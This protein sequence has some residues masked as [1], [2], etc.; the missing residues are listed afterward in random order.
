MPIGLRHLILR[1][2]LGWLAAASV[3][4]AS[5]VILSSESSAAYTQA[6]QALIGELERRGVPRNELLSVT[7]LEWTSATPVGAKLIVTLGA[8]ASEVVAQS[9]VQIPVLCTLLPLASFERL[10]RAHGRRAS[11]RFTALYLDQP[12]DRQLN[13]IRQAL[14]KAKRLGVLWGPASI[15]QAS[16]L[17]TQALSR[18]LTLVSASVDTQNSLFD[19]LQEVL[20][21]ADLLLALPDP[22]V[23]NSSTVQNIL[24]A[25]FR[26]KTPVVAFSPSYARAGALLAVYVT[27]TQIGVQAGTLASAVL[28]GKELPAAPIPSHDFEVAINEQL[29]HSLSLR[30]N[31]HELREKLLTEEARP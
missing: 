19:A 16:A 22:Q 17:K 2:V 4:A 10:L 1:F 5:I 20:Q 27:P 7:L 23:Y 29:A 31:A 21:D 9:A 14:P 12:F 8:Q 26:A 6:S 15:A 11:P 18:G 28:L 3:Q 25:S 24:L 13:L 30:L